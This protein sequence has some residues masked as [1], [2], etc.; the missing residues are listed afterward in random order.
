MS[1]VKNP[2]RTLIL[3]AM[4]SMAAADG[5]LHESE[6]KTI[7][8]LYEQISGVALSASDISTAQMDDLP[9]GFTF[10]D[11]LA[12][13]RN[14]LTRELKQVILSS[15]YMVLLADGRVSAHERK[16]LSDIVDALKIS[17]IQRS[18]IC[19]DVERTLH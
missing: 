9:H 13:A 14:Q 2:S 4:I 19:E 16:T 6:L 1:N 17:D 7:R 8:T 10:A 11:R 5:D 15:A 18:I 3:Q 12:N